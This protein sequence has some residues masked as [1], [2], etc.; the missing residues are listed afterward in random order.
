MNS[1]I[2]NI[3]KKLVNVGR[4]K[5]EQVPKE[6]K[7]FFLKPDKENTSVEV[8]PEETIEKPGAFIIPD[9]IKLINIEESGIYKLGIDIN[10][11]FM[12]NTIGSHMQ[13][14]NV[15]VDV[16]R[17]EVNLLQF[18]HSSI[19]IEQ[20]VGP[21]DGFDVKVMAELNNNYNCNQLFRIDA[22]ITADNYDDQMYV[23]IYYN[24]K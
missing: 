9:I 21:H 17:V 24:K 16:R 6:A 7:E 20:I 13:P 10:E 2:A 22:A 3:Y 19:K 14:E 5:E 11:I 1:V 8:E 4:L 12:P 18:K 15:H 23:T